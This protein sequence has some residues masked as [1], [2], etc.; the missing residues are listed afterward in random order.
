MGGTRG[1]HELGFTEHIFR[2]AEVVDL[3]GEWWAD[4]PDERLREYC[5]TY[6]AEHAT[7]SL[8]DY[9]ELLE[10]ARAE[11]LPIRSGLEVDYYPG[12]MDEL[13][14][15][16]AG[17][18]LDFCLGSVH[19]IGGWGFDDPAVADEWS[20]R[21]VAETWRKYFQALGEMVSSGVA[22]VLAHPDLVK[23]FGHRPEFEPTDLYDRVLNSASQR[24]IAI[25]VS[26]AGLRKPVGE[27]YPSAAFLDRARL[28]GVEITTASDAHLAGDVGR[29]F[30]KIRSL[31]ENAGYDRVASFS[32]REKVMIS[33]DGEPA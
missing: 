2:F 29:D 1:V 7:Q 5:K 26:S 33:F 6:F 30:D 16:L 18:P 19:W 15:F 21:D 27:A 24:G 17:Y 9:L 28:A 12:R 13:A 20:D 10:D 31:A 23:V 22:D 25:E 32:R 14:K 4:E 3:L 11:G 8:D